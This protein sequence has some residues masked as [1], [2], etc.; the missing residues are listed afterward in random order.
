[1]K[2]TILITHT[3]S[4][5]F[6]AENGQELAGISA[7]WLTEDFEQNRTTL[8]GDMLTLVEKSKL[9]AL[10]EADVK[11]VQK[12]NNGKASLKYEINSLQPLKQVEIFKV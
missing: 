6:K 2:T 9:P 10:F 4:W 3:N 8:K 12:Y 7:V 1:M 5:R 11:A